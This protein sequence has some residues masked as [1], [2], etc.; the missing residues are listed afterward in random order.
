MGTA[1]FAGGLV[2]LPLSQSFHGEV[3]G[4][5]AGVEPCPAACLQ[6]RNSTSEIQPCW[7]KGLE[8]QQLV[9]RK[10]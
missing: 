3:R 2:E 6:S 4:I 5:T 1:A 7:R 8:L 9:A 10:L